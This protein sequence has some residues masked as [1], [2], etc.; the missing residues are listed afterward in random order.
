MSFQLNIIGGFLCSLL[1]LLKFGKTWQKQIE[2]KKKKKKKQMMEK[3]KHKQKNGI[4]SS[5]L[6]LCLYAKIIRDYPLFVQNKNK[7]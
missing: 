3:T 4:I 2:N 5:T 6:K 7:K 1:I